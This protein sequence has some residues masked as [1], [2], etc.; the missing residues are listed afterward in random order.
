VRIPL[1]MSFY[2]LSSRTMD[3]VRVREGDNWKASEVKPQYALS[4]AGL[5]TPDT[6]YYWHVR[7][8]NA[9]GLWGPWSKTFSFTAWGAAYPLDVKL[10]WDAETGLGTLKWK[11]NPVGR[12]PAKY[13]VYGSDERGFIVMDSNRQLALGDAGKSD[14]K[15]WNPWAPANFLAETTDTQLVV[16]GPEVKA[17]NRTYYRVVV[18]D[19]RGKRSGPSDYAEGPRPTI[20]TRPLV[21]A[22]AGEDYKYQVRANR[23][24]GDL[25]SGYFTVEKPKFA[26]VTGPA[27]LKIDEST[28]VLSGVPASAGKVEVVVRAVI[29]RK[30]RKLDESKLIWGVEKVLSEGVERVGE[31]TQKYVI[32]VQ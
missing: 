15:E 31:A 9:K 6:K 30:V 22:K 26:L 14:L 21:T 18:V 29:D 32:D 11:A 5:L 28:G 24:L 1:S 7:A 17:G 12:R 20:Y 23:S 10:G 3:A 19:E 16:M 13:R 27:W 4:E 8:R 25:P 2:K